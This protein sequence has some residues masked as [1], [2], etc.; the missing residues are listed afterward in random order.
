LLHRLLPA[1]L[2]WLLAGVPFLS[3]LLERP[4]LLSL[5]THVAAW[6]LAAMALDF[7]LGL[8]GIV[9]IG[10]AG[11]VGIG[12]YAT[13]IAM[14]GGVTEFVALAVLAAAAAAAYGLTTGA[15]ALR[16]GPLNVILVTFASGAVLAE[17]A[18]GLPILGGM[19]GLAT[20]ERPTLAGFRF[21]DGERAMF[22]AAFAILVLA[23]A[24]L[25]LLS[26]SPFGRALAAVGENSARAEA[27]GLMPF[28]HRLQAYVISAAVA[29]LAG[30]LI[31]VIDLTARPPIMAWQR[32]A[33][34]LVMAAIGAPLP[35]VG[36]VAGAAVVLWLK[37]TLMASFGL[38]QGALGILV[39]GLALL[40]LKLL[41]R[42]P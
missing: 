33:E 12:A 24:A 13:L 11:F 26:H 34:L 15:L 5:G 9:A 1:L 41:R 30:S 37:E 16:G 31:A 14:T 40:R 35:L 19:Q 4:Q 39:A 3:V 42:R 8:G 22:W 32:S 20:A 7:A 27:L 23:Y 38:W 21:L 2:L 10:H 28:R 18:L 36:A 17:V 25:V 6:G 29:G